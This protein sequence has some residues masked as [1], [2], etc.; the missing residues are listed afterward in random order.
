MCWVGS[1]HKKWG[2]E[3]T[4]AQKSRLSL[5][6]ERV[7]L[8]QAENRDTPS[9]T[10]NFRWTDLTSDGRADRRN[11]EVWRRCDEVSI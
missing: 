7:R 2:G 1:R 4:D 6:E 5:T 10:R 9:E 8:S 3:E 11:R